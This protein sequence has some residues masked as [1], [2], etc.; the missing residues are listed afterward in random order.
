M[1]N[2]AE[3]NFKKCKKVAISKLKL[4]KKVLN[5]PDD[6]DPQEKLKK[7]RKKPFFY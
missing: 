4:E 1:L 6:D 3:K 5:I 2:S 7:I